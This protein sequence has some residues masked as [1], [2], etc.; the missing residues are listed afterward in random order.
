MAAET[1]RTDWR[2]VLLI[3]AAGLGAAAQYGKISVI[4]DRLPEVYPQAGAALGFAVSFVGFLGIVLGV[5]AGVL[6]ARIGYRRALL[7]ALI[8]GAAVSAVQ[9]LFPPMPVFLALRVV[10]GAAH[11]AIVVAGPT[12]VAQITAEA[13]RGLALTL[14]G[15]FFG[16]A[17]A[18][19]AWAGVP[20][21]HWV[22]LP[23]LMLAHAAY[24]ALMAAVLWPILPRVTSRPAAAP[25]LADLAR[26]HRRI[27]LSPFIGAPA[28]GWVFYTACFV[29][30]LTVI[31]PY[32]PDHIRAFTVGAMPLMSILSSLTL[33]VWLL[34][35]IE[36]VQVVML[37]FAACAALCVLL[38]V[39]PGAPVLALAL[40]AGLGLVQ[41]ASFAA[42][43]QLNLALDDRALANGGLAQAGNLGNTL[44]TPLMVGVIAL[45]GYGGLM[46]ALGLLFCAGGA[47]HVGLRR[48][49][50][51]QIA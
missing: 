49:R 7:A 41:G 34:R 37:G 32:L 46:T 31:P 26:A 25:R 9:S 36:A 35:H 4:F 30:V 51:R 29:A 47:V 28:Y 39:F 18:I 50:L 40:G 27:Y 21:A 3:W 5:V 44:G 38:A 45:G 42:V 6:V 23:A 19:L 22:G 15:T 8:T 13:D 24:M 2:L 12:M 33:G 14:W 1:Q 16:V 11:L 48:R 20:F 17:F 43:P 10:E